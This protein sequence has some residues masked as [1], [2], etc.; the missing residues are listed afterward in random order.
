VPTATAVPAPTGCRRFYALDGQARTFIEAEQ[1][2]SMSGRFVAQAAA[3]RSAGNA[4]R[5]PGSGM[6][7]DKNTYLTF[8]LQVRDGGTFSV[9]LLGYGPDGSADSFFVQVD[10]GSAVEAILTRGSWNWKRVA[11]TIKIGA[12]AHTLTIKNR[13]DGASVDKILLIKDK[14]YTPAGLGDAALTPQCR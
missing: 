14:G 3:E 13:E 1:Y 11:S 9:W 8:D 10:D 7:K 2:T 6:G 12:G 5:I 4:M